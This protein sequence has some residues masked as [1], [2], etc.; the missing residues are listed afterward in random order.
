MDALET[1]Q[2]DAARWAGISKQRLSDWKRKPKP[3][4]AD[5]NTALHAFAA[6]WILKEVK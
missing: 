3:T 6:R 1:S 2:T 5:I 4:K